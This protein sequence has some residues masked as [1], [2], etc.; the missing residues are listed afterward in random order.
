MQETEKSIRDKIA[1]LMKVSSADSLEID[2]VTKRNAL[3]YAA[4]IGDLNTLH[5]ILL[6]SD[7]CDFHCE[8][9]KGDT[10]LE[11]SVRQGEYEFAKAL[12]K[13]GADINATNNYSLTMMHRA[14]EKNDPHAVKFYL[15]QGIDFTLT[16]VD[17]NTPLHLAAKLTKPVMMGM[18]MKEEGLKNLKE[19]RNY[20]GET[21]LEIAL[22]KKN[23]AMVK[24]MVGDDFCTPSLMPGYGAVK[25]N[26]S[27]LHIYNQLIEYNKLKKRDFSALDVEGN[28]HG[29]GFQMPYYC[30][31]EN[32][33]E[34]EFYTILEL[35]SVWGKNVKKMPIEAQDKS[36]SHFE[37]IKKQLQCEQ[38][39]KLATLNA[40]HEVVEGLS[41]NYQNLDELLSQWENEIAWFQ[42]SFATLDHLNGSLASFQQLRKKQF[43]IAKKAGETREFRFLHSSQPLILTKEQLSEYFEIW[44]YHPK[45]IMEL[46]GSM[47]TT[48]V[49][50]RK[51]GGF[52]YYDPNAEYKMKIFLFSP[53]IGRSSV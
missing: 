39:A 8:D 42:Q 29:L 6:M 9:N 23:D 34:N 13:E 24:V 49:Y 30:S 45:A 11:L 53:R 46:G 50:V 37:Q 41:G 40:S 10:P 21:A 22:Q 44:S 47:H 20:Y 28:C 16:D 48:V 26:I 15:A 35:I 3:H 52:F 43:E 31:N 25:P 51:G 1:E 4:L 19:E 33:D 27:Q 2:P 32:S 14:I 17:G 5:E 7:F 38:D 36:L 12:I 18:L